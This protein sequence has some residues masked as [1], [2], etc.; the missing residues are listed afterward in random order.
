M[1]FT[2]TLLKDYLEE[3]NPGWKVVWDARG[4]LVEPHTKAK[5]SLGGLGVKRYMDQWG[6][7]I[8]NDVPSVS[9]LIDTH[10][11]ENRFSNVL[12]IEK[13]GF[14][15]ILANAGIS[16]RYDMAIM[17]TKGIPVDAACDLIDNMANEGVQVFVLHD[18]DAAGFKILRTLREG[19]RLSV[20]TDVIDLGLRM[21]DIGELPSEPVSYSQRQHPA[22]YLE[23]DCGVTKEEVKFL[24]SGGYP[25]RWS[26]RRVEINA[27]TS[28]QLITWLEEKFD[29]HG[30][31]KMI[32]DEDTLTA[33]Y[34]RAAFAHR[35]AVEI[36]RLREEMTDDAAAPE[37]LTARVETMLADDPSMS[38]D[39]AVWRVAEGESE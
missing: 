22:I 37:G 16:E 23:Y 5:I 10:G 14:A 32:P 11:P 7:N 9:S 31:S 13:E 34:Q 3:F 6:A 25:G 19:T 38:W 12:F 26:G 24:V 20:G 36:D 1:Y 18:F 33:A 28:E 17:S 27:M 4:H 30:I 39:M 8:D 15:E 35:M 2:Q 29:E 21:E